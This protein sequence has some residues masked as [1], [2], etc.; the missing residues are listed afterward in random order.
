MPISPQRASQE[1]L[2]CGATVRLA[3]AGR[4]TLM[5]AA[6]SQETPDKRGRR[7]TLLRLDGLARVAETAF[8]APQLTTLVAHAEGGNSQALSVVSKG[9][10]AAR[11]RW[12]GPGTTPSQEIAQQHAE[13]FV[14]AA[15][16]GDAREVARLLRDPGEPS[17]LLIRTLATLGLPPL[18]VC[19]GERS[20]VL[21]GVRGATVHQARSLWQGM[22]DFMSD[23]TDPNPPLQLDGL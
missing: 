8:D 5:E 22:K 4:W 1:L 13:L 21:A 19:F 10:T 3:P 14:A 12:A 11:H 15:G 18:P 16:S 2:L 7:A 9:R 6:P 20:E 17:E 23:D